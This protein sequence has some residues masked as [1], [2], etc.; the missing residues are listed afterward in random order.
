MKEN[1]RSLVNRRENTEILLYY[2]QIHMKKKYSQKPTAGV[3][4]NSNELSRKGIVNIA[5]LDFM[6]A[7]WVSEV[8]ENY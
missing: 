8:V 3:F 7:E 4:V 1:T 6:K 2:T 5:H